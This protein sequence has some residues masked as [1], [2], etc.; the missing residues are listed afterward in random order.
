MLGDNS[1][2]WHG[3]IFGMTCRIYP[4][5][6]RCNPRP[7]WA[8][9]DDLGLQQPR[10]VGWWDAASPVLVHTVGGNWDVRATL[11]VAGDSFAVAVANFSPRKATFKISFASSRLA[12]LGL[13]RA[14]RMRLRA[15]PINGFQVAGTW[16]VGGVLTL[17]GK[18][19]GR[20][21]GYLLQLLP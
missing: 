11:F 3:L 14:K 19:T 6:D 8:A 2:Q 4:D 13:P 7:L 20:K 9:L 17:A 15:P 5:P 10:M 16:G 12:V 21:E 18:G 1:D